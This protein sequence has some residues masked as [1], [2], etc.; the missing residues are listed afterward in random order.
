MVKIVD[1]IAEE[2]GSSKFP[3]VGKQDLSSSVPSKG[4]WSHVVNSV[5]GF[6]VLICE[7]FFLFFLWLVASLF[8][9]SERAVL[10]TGYGTLCFP[11]GY[12]QSSFSR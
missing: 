11:S 5:G 2:E 10:L 6:R 4:T 12:L 3:C 7:S 8:V 1:H 9:D